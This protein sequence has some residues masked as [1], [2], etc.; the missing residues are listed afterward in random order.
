MTDVYF[1]EFIAIG[2][3]KMAT[4]DGKNACA[5][6]FCGNKERVIQ[7]AEAIQNL[8]KYCEEILNESTEALDKI[9]L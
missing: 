1:N 7:Y 2:N 3:M 8:C 6:S 9:K 4:E 5:I